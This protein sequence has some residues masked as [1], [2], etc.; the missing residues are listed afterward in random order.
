MARR[1]SPL[2]I[3]KSLDEFLAESDT[4]SDEESQSSRRA[5]TSRLSALSRAV[6]SRSSSATRAPARVSRPSSVSTRGG[7]G[8]DSDSRSEDDRS[9]SGVRSKVADLKRGVRERGMG[10]PEEGERKKAPLWYDSDESDEEGDTKKKPPP[11]WLKQSK[12]APPTHEPTQSSKS[13]LKSID[14]N[15]P[16]ASKSTPAAS[17]PAQDSNRNTIFMRNRRTATLEDFDPQAVRIASVALQDTSDDRIS[18]AEL[19][20]PTPKENRDSL[21]RPAARAGGLYSTTEGSTSKSVSESFSEES[22][23]DIDE[24]DDDV[25][26]DALDVSL[27][28]DRTEDDK[29]KFFEALEG[30]KEG[31]DYGA[32]M[33][34]LS[35]EDEDVSVGSIKELLAGIP[36]EI[37][38]GA[39]AADEAGV[40]T[41][42]PPATVVEKSGSDSDAGKDRPGHVARGA[43]SNTGDK[44]MDDSDFSMEYPE[45]QWPSFDNGRDLVTLSER[46]EGVGDR[47]MAD[48]A[49][50]E[51]EYSMSF[52]SVTVDGVHQGGATGDAPAQ[53]VNT[54]AGMDGPT[55]AGKEVHLDP[56]LA[57]ELLKDDTPS[58]DD[59]NAHEAVPILPPVS[60][61]IQSAPT[62]LVKQL[63]DAVQVVTEGRTDE[64]AVAI[65]GAGSVQ[66]S[67]IAQSLAPSDSTP[68]TADAVPPTIT[69]SARQLLP[70]SEERQDDDAASS[71]MAIGAGAMSESSRGQSYLT[72]SD[73][74]AMHDDE[75]PGEKKAPVRAKSAPATGTSLIPRP[76]PKNARPSTA[77]APTTASL[78]RQAALER[79]N[80]KIRA[81]RSPPKPPFRPAGRTPI[82]PGPA[83]RPPTS[84]IRSPVRS[85][86]RQHR[87]SPTRSPTRQ[88]HSPSPG[89]GL[90]AMTPPRPTHTLDAEINP[91]SSFT[92]IPPPSPTPHD[93]E[94][95]KDLQQMAELLDMKSREVD[96]LKEELAFN[97]RMKEGQGEQSWMRQER[98]LKLESQDMEQIRKDIEEQEVLIRGYQLENE[99]LVDQI[100]SLKQDHKDAERLHQLKL[101]SALRENT[102]LKNQLRDAQAHS[103]PP[104]DFNAAKIQVRAEKLEIELREAQA[105]EEGLKGEIAKL[106]AQLTEAHEQID[107]LKDA[108]PDVVEKLRSDMKEAK[109]RYEAYIV[110]LEGKV[111]WHVENQEL[112]AEKEAMLQEREKE[113]DEAKRKTGGVT[114]KRGSAVVMGADAKRIKALEK[115]VGEL[116]RALKKKGRPD[117]IAE[118]VKATKPTIEEGT[119]VK[120]LREKVRKLEQEV[121]VARADG[122]RSVRQLE[123]QFNRIREAY[124]KRIVDLTAAAA[125]REAA[126]AAQASDAAA[127]RISGL[128]KQLSDLLRSYSDK[129][130]AGSGTTEEAELG[131]LRGREAALRRRVA[132]LQGVVE[133]QE[134]RLD[135]ERKE[136]GNLQRSWRAKLEEKDA[137]IAGYEDKVARL[138]RDV[139]DKVFAVEEGKALD[140]A[141]RWKAEAERARVEISDLRTK[142]EISEGTRRAVHENTIAILKQA[143]EESAKMALSHHERALAALRREI[144]EE[145]RHAASAAA[146]D[147]S[148]EV[149][150]LRERV[151]ELEDQVTLWKGKAER[152]EKMLRDAQE[153]AKKDMGVMESTVRELRIENTHLTS[154]LEE[155]RRGWPLPL[156]RFDELSTRIAELE[157]RARKREAE[158]SEMMERA[159]HVAV[160]GGAVSPKSGSSVDA[161][162]A[163]KAERR[164][165]MAMIEKKDREI[166][167]FRMEMEK[168]VEG[169]MELK[170]QGVVM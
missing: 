21:P 153:N 61:P 86:T 165:L 117:P 46:K 40:E 64:K 154:G 167:R 25:K 80:A 17:N 113:L 164:R 104:S 121:E 115:Q 145:T 69:I 149:R 53:A 95:R 166:D 144:M 73:F 70:M 31:I 76:S 102:H 156:R 1:T 120:H 128:E 169:I 108:A 28:L 43:I 47:S 24:D 147:A 33:E 8:N 14:V 27:S 105:K 107:A 135:A 158:V 62:E 148:G 116:E 96:V 74:M 39:A 125:Q 63:S 98:I 161:S 122:A 136:R 163:V 124:E 77:T 88:L 87:H 16:P 152:G 170:R 44:L 13:P 32:L 29:E 48:A 60:E 141:S 127:G 126:A 26:E 90:Y 142:L 22:V 159:A 65:A 155:A 59:I 84:P 82:H 93:A 5:G 143:Q 131:A 109:A 162:V 91:L 140:Q 103:R 134:R 79:A 11:Q 35:D 157:A 30:R 12:P 99:K 83:D 168:V 112:L 38:A 81:A 7:Y 94:W 114:G 138:Q 58:A 18:T 41:S 9:A 89:G 92:P 139:M 100:K 111:A 15:V 67:D 6:G 2:D 34:E 68:Q 50:A 56:S 55:S 19:L 78:A 57:K 37:A 133:E 150:R 3:P 36:A 75:A 85:P 119:Y 10:I 72:F 66:G 52:D 132:E 123:E 45:I 110:E 106:R 137:L 4:S 20:N 146:A 118:L 130:G 51:D 160:G 71:T 129:I 42:A 101:E 151:A 97:E 54:D 49:T 23:S